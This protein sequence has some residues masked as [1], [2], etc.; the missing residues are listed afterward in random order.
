M[1]FAVGAVLSAG[2]YAIGLNYWLLVGAFVGLIE[3]V[4]VIGPLIGSILVLA[5]GAP[6]SLHIAALALL[7][8]VVVR[9][10]Q[11]YVVNPHIGR[12]VGLSPL[13][14]LLSVAVVGLLFGGLAVIL[15]VPFTSAVATLIDVLVLGHE[16]P[17]AEPRRSLRLRRS[18]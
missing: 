12:T 13:V 2:F 18:Q 6:Q 3:I 15:A 9:E 8:L 10:F 17:A 14:T 1:V 7:W 4:P 11:N 5:V 16:P